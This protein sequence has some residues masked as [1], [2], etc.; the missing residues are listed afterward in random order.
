MYTLAG[1]RLKFFGM[2]EMQ[3]VLDSLAT[4]G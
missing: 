3:E 1:C 4:G 2:G